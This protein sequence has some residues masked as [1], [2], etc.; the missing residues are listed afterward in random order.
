M[1]YRGKLKEQTEAR[2]L[3]ARGLTMADI[4]TRLRVSKGSVSAWTRDVPFQPSLLKTKARR[5]GPNILQLRKLAE[6]EA[7]RREGIARVGQLSRKQFLVAGAALYAAEG[8]KADWEVAFANADARMVAF[9][10]AW[11]R[12]FFTIDETRL[13]LRL[14]LHDGLDLEAAICFWTNITG[15][16]PAQVL[17]PYRAVPDP[18]IRRAKHLH[19]CATVRYACSATHRAITGLVDALLASNAIPG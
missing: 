9:F 11:L 19:G 8:S 4:A 5:R 17:K 3:R 18:S 10:C 15:V 12:T 14:Y 13:R 2:R 6:I 1:G 7:L 16:P